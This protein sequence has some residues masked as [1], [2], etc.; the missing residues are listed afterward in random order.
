MAMVQRIGGF[1]WVARLVERLPAVGS[2]VGNDAISW[3][4]LPI[5]TAVAVLLYVRLR[6]ERDG[7]DQR[8]LNEQLSS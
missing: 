7:L 3:L 2:S 8:A 1:E 6:A 4:L 5:E